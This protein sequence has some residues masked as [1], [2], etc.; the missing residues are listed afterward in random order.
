MARTHDVWQTGTNSTYIETISP[1]GYDL[2]INGSNHYINFGTVVGSSGYGFRDNAGTIQWKNSG[3]A[4]ANIGSGGG[5]STTFIGLTD[6]PASYTGNA[7]KS[8]RVNAGETALEFYVASGSG[9]VSKVGTPNNTEIGVWTGDGTLGRS[10]NFIYNGNV[11]AFGG[12]TP[13][14]WNSNTGIIEGGGASTF[15]G[16]VG[17]MWMTSNG[18]F[19]SG[20][21]YKAN[22][23]AANIGV[24]D[25]DV[26]I[27][28]AASGLLGDPLTFLMPFKAYS[29]GSDGFVGLGGNIT[30]TSNDLTGAIVQISST[31]VIS[32]VDITVPDEAYGV[33]WNANL[34][35]PTK[36]AVYDKIEAV[37]ATIPSAY[38]D[39]MAQ[40]AVGA[41]VNTSLTYVDG[42]P[43]LGLTSRTIGGVAFDGTANITVATA[44]GGFTVSGGNLALGTNSI[45]MSGSIGVTG[46]RVTK[47]WATDI[48]STNM[49]TVGGT[50]LSSTFAAQATTLTVAGTANQITSS[51]GAQDLSAN[52]TWTLSLP[53]DVL[54]PTVLTVPNTGLH[55]LDTNA[56]HDLIIKP[57]SN[58]TAD[59]TFTITTGDTDMIV[60][61]TAV[62]D[63]YVLAYDTGTNTWRGVVLAP[64]G[65]ASTALDNLASVAINTS[66]ISDTDAT[67]DL[68][69]AA[70]KWNNI[71]GVNLGATGTRFTTG[72]F[73]DLTVTNAITGSVT[74]NAATVTT[75]A[76]LTGHVT[77][78]GNAAV[79]GSFTKAQ[80]DTA[81]SDGN[82]L[83]VGDISQYTDEL[84]QDA[85]GAMVNTSLTYVD[86]TPSLG[87]TSRTIGGV[88]FDG[89]ANITVA[90]ATGGFT[91]SGG[92]LALGT[93]SITMS[94]SIGV[95]GTRVTKGWFTDLE[96][97]NTIVGSINGN[98]A[99][100]T[101][102]AVGGITGLGTG[103]AT[104]LAIN[105]GSAGAFVTFN[106]ALGTPSSGT[107]TNLTG[108]ASININGTVGATTPAAGTFTAAIANSFV[109]NL[110]TIPTN[111][112]YLPAAN[113]LGWAI[114]S[115]AEL[116]LTGTAL[117]P[118]S[119][120]GLAL[121]TTAL[122][123]Q[124]LFGDTGFVLN[125]E[126]S[127]WV[128]THTS[129][130]LTVG[131]GDLRVTNNFT[132]AT[133]VATLGGAQ[134]FTNKTL[135]SPI[136][137]TPSAFTTGG[138]ITLAE[139]TSIALDPAGS[140]DGKFT[141][142]TVTAT[143]GYTQ[144]FGDLVYLDPTDS[145][146]EAC[147][148]NSA[149]GAD[150]DSRG[151][152]GMVV[153]AGTDGA[154]CT[155]LLQGII[156]ADAKFPSFTINNPIYASE[157]AGSVTQ[158]QPVTTDVVIRI[159]G[160]A[161]TADEM[162]FNPSNDYITH[163]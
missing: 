126:N 5:G 99:T 132:D 160:F 51:A 79:L 81:V 150:G 96:V 119:D 23:K 131:T 151:I 80:L 97:T 144:A 72:W 38:T 13:S 57:G 63:E 25:G 49:P 83:F 121:G 149:A 112:M 147:D 48:E 11:L 4:W 140:A 141:G 30:T 17:D 106:G 64:G 94:G 87:L 88:A 60:D 139:N 145:R 102:V 15:Y 113:T 124:S 21:K 130:I 9:D 52:R 138:T 100:A 90:T 75:N 56:S 86:G 54:I 47:L 20:W 55:L 8:L 93:N 74:G 123:W 27:R 46:T 18:Y 6:V 43:S 153:V 31:I 78:V 44:T 89:T 155:I 58:I 133:S 154:A 136:L 135:T 10:A 134:T 67:D 70:V 14:T 98:A 35:V 19:N 2:L 68:G 110:S 142:T 42:T 146:W 16:T 103:V 7:L 159:V 62:T 40:D 162:Y 24:Y 33:G 109:P 127:N 65:G 157:T 111:G 22:G 114:N 143:A 122:G 128:A 156:R 82:V 163:I 66:L 59:R 137:T 120:D 45:T 129:G 91:V 3:G 39:E 118:M 41:M 148:A 115:A 77:S 28:G 108:T 158:T 104:A 37:I 73:T 61:F 12:T 84:A 34:E 95:T 125:I 69:S 107:V 161:I 105:V 1:T 85:V 117:S 76:N 101:N 26:W 92:N 36:N 53:A 152:I 29:N 71:F 116:Q 50:S 32:A